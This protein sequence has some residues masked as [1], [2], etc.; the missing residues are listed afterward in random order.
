MHGL[1]TRAICKATKTLAEAIDE[2]LTIRIGRKLAEIVDDNGDIIHYDTNA[3]N[4]CRRLRSH[5]DEADL[6]S[7]L[8]PELELEG[9]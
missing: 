3:P 7:L 8:M 6:T 9:V 1:S 4:L 5:A 2:R